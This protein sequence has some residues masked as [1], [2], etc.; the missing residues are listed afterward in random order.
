MTG[1]VPGDT[2]RGK[3]TLVAGL[4]LE[5]RMPRSQ[6]QRIVKH[7]WYLHKNIKNLII[8]QGAGIVP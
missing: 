1:R 8:F 5:H 6:L 4:L 7:A 2:G 3:V